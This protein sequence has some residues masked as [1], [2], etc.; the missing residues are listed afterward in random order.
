MTA[1]ANPEVV[2]D[3]RHHVRD[4]KAASGEVLR[5]LSAREVEEISWPWLRPIR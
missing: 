5:E 2:D 3:L 1:L 4:E